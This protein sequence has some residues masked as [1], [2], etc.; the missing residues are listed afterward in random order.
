[1]NC[2][3]AAMSAAES[4]LEKPGIGPMPLEMLVVSWVA[5]RFAAQAAGGVLV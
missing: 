2:T 3:M 5:E 1:M 4:E